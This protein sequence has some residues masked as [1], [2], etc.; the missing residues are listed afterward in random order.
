MSQADDPEQS[1][2]TKYIEVG[3][4]L[5]QALDSPRQLRQLGEEPSPL[6]SKGLKKPLSQILHNERNKAS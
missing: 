5:R 3:K 4:K 6:T 2:G 1:S